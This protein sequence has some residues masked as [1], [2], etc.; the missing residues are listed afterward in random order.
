MLKEESKVLPMVSMT[1]ESTGLIVAVALEYRD[2]PILATLG[3]VAFSGSWLLI[4]LE[5]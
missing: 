5:M 3:L 4:R 2:K 1:G